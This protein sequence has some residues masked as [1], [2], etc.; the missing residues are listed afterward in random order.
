MDY[1]VINP[2]FK[3]EFGKKYRVVGKRQERGLVFKDDYL[4]PYDVK[5]YTVYEMVGEDGKVF[6]ITKAVAKTMFGGF[7]EE[8]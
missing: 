4:E 3:E 8:D 2:L 1:V 6:Q 7:Y 5:T